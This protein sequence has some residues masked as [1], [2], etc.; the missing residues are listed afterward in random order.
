MKRDSLPLVDSHWRR[1]L[2]ILGGAYIGVAVVHLVIEAV[3]MRPGA[4]FDDRVALIFTRQILVPLLWLTGLVLLPMVLI[5]VGLVRLAFPAA[6]GR[7]PAFG[8][9]I[10]VGTGV[11]LLLLSSTWGNAIRRDGLRAFATRAEP[12][13]RAIDAYERDHGRPPPSLPALVPEYITPSSLEQLRL[14]A[15]RTAHFRVYTLD[16]RARGP[17][18]EIVFECPQPG[19]TTLDHLHYAS[20]AETAPQLARQ[21]HDY[22]LGWRYVWD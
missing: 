10:I 20:N 4:P 6:A 22:F 3:L 13:V 18:W 19:M 14:R 16:L 11:Y 8:L 7:V 5:P 21:D 9:L 15:C 1:N 2:A 12:V 17:R